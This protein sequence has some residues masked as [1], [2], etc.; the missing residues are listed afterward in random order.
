MDKL[1]TDISEHICNYVE[2]QDIYRLTCVSTK[3]Q[4]WKKYL[5]DKF[6]INCGLSKLCHSDDVLKNIE[7]S[8]R[9]N[10]G[11]EIHLS[12]KKNP[13]DLVPSSSEN[14]F[15]DKPFIGEFLLTSRRKIFS[16]VN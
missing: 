9:H 14:I 7:Y 2:P 11:C 12:K 4:E 1:H 10:L 6:L 5:A 15:V 8:I 16:L 13:I 3:F